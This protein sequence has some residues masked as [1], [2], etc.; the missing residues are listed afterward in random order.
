MISMYLHRLIFGFLANALH[1]GA[2][3]ITKLI[4]SRPV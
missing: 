4:I 3:N 1:F 2:D